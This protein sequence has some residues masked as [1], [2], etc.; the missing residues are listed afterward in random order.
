MG[1]NK[2]ALPVS[3]SSG[4][5]DDKDKERLINDD[6]FLSPTKEAA[7]IDEEF[8]AYIAMTRAQEK[9]YISYSLI[10]K[11][12]KENFA[13]P[14]LNTVKSLFPELKEKQTSKIFRVFYCGL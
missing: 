12:F 6:I 4:L 9:T 13:S 11:S 1:F 10:D 5:I 8:V 7:L 2:D 14:Y 3:K